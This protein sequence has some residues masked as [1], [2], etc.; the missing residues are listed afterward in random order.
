MKTTSPGLLGRF[1]PLFGK[2]LQSLSFWRFALSTR[3]TSFRFFAG[4]LSAILVLPAIAQSP[5]TFS[6]KLDGQLHSDPYARGPVVWDKLSLDDASTLGLPLKSGDRLFKG[7]LELSSDP[8]IGVDGVIV[9]SM[10][11]TDVLYADLN[12]NGRFEESERFQFQPVTDSVLEGMFKSRVEI[13]LPLAIGSY[14]SCPMEVFILGGGAQFVGP[15]TN[16]T[17]TND[18]AASGN[19]FLMHSA[20][21]FVEGTAQL[22]DR[23]LLMRFAYNFKQNAVDLNHAV[24]WADVRGDGS[25]KQVDGNDPELRWANGKPP[26]FRAGNSVISAQSI[27]LATNTFVLRTMPPADY[28]IIDLAVGMTVPDFAFTGFDG[29]LH[30]LSEIKA[31]Y[32]L[33]D[34]W[35]AECSP[36]VADLPSKAKAYDEFHGRGFEI[37]G[38][39]AAEDE[40]IEKAQKLLNKMKIAWPQA[41]Y[42]KEL[43]QNE[44]LSPGTPSFV[45]IDADRKIVSIGDAKHLPLDG[46]NLIQTLQTLLPDR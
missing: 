40:S 32:L 15:S 12:K 16:F 11:G 42:D 24:E 34:F 31:K 46:E 23:S 10:D 26:S 41:R 1:S 13:E 14:L 4:I 21:A 20:G 18:S 27:D 29:K 19:I 36:C 37:L 5:S 8:K 6:G 35:F 17:S 7:K 38:M 30:H 43:F 33:L 2:I 3:L 45:L 44:L 25:R 28:H 39:D 9:R 22:P